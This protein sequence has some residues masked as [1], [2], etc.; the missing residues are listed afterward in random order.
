[1]TT[2][3]ATT[4]S[5]ITT[6]ALIVAAAATML[7]LRLQLLLQLSAADLLYP[8]ATISHESHDCDAFPSY[9]QQVLFQQQSDASCSERQL[10]E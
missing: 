10:Q 1:M 8:P 6:T 9:E 7:Q 3:T 5:I 4:I 2:T